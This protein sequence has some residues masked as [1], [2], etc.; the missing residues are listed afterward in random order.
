MKAEGVVSYLNETVGNIIQSKFPKNTVFEEKCVDFM[1]RAEWI[2]PFGEA[3]DVGSLYGF[4]N[5]DQ[6]SNVNIE[7]KNYLRKHLMCMICRKLFRKE[8]SDEAKENGKQIDYR[9]NHKK[10]IRNVHPYFFNHV[11]RKDSASKVHNARKKR[12]NGNQ[13]TLFTLT[14]RKKRREEEEEP[15]CEYLLTNFDE[16]E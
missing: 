5:I 8:A 2:R 9:S 11:L 3:A 13:P 14:R 10:H 12:I 15:F 1:I 7:V 6:I 16:K 4:F